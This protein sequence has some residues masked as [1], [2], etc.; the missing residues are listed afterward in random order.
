MTFQVIDGVRVWGEPDADSLAQA[1]RCARVGDV[2]A[3]ALMADHHKGYSQPIGGVVAYRGAVSPSGVGY[4]I[5]CGNKAVRTDL[6]INDVRRDLPRIMDTIARQISFGMGRKNAK[7]IDHDL[8]DD[9]TWRDVPD[10]LPLQRL[11][12]EQ[13]GTVGAGNHYVDILVEPATDAVWVAV[14]FGSRGFGHRTATGFL[15]L[16]AGRAFDAKPPRESMD[17]DPTLL[18]LQTDLGQAYMAAMALAGRYAYAGRD[19]V[20]DEV[21]AILG[22]RSTFAVHNHHNFAWV[23]QHNGEEVVVVRKGATPLAPGQLG[24]VG[25]SMADIA[26]IIRGVDT[27]EARQALLSTVHGAGR[28]MSRTQ[29]AGRFQWR[30]RKRT[31]G[32]ISPKQMAQAVRAYGVELRGGGP[33]ESPFVYRK[34]E[35]VLAAHRGTLEVVHQLRPVGVAMAG[36]DEHDPYRD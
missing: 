1:V 27:A 2:A 4:D 3:V 8:F 24:F 17:Q 34:L 15:N 10:L 16:A 9:P 12:R 21:L 33:D 32:V 26:V 5:A 25:G 7:P 36:P 18:S 14:H 29:A 6:H 22:A 23:E 20:T 19:Y 30:T 28:I 11:A 35:Q 13:L 31:G